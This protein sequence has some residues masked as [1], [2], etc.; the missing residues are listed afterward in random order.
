MNTSQTTTLSE[1]IGSAGVPLGT[2]GYL[3][4]RNKRRAYNIVLKE[5]KKSKLSQADLAKRMGKRPD[6][7][8]RLLGG[9]GNWTLDTVSDL[10][11]AISGA[12]LKFSLSYPLRKSPRNLRSPVWLSVPAVSSVG[13]P[14]T[15]TGSTRVNVKELVIS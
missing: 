11:F 9:P 4:A 8:C 2:L 5:F 1:P 13:A 12:E 10:L 6:V 3:R 15:A 7:V 14:T